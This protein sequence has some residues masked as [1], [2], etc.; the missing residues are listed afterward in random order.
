MIQL[1]VRLLTTVFISA[2]LCQASGQ[3]PT[4]PEDKPTREEAFRAAV[5]ILEQAEQQQLDDGAVQATQTEEINRRLT[6][7]Q[8]VDP[9][10]PWLLYLYGRA[11][12][13]A[14]RT[15]EAI[16]H[17]RKFVETREGRNEWQAHRRLGDLF[18]AEFPRL[19]KAS[20]SKALVL[21][22]GE[23]TALLGLSVCAYKTG[24]LDEAL[25]LAQQAVDADGRQTVRF[26]AQLT[27][28]LIAKQQWADADRTAVLAM[29]LA[30]ADVRKRPGLRGPLKTLEAQFDLLADLS[31]A[32]IDQK[33]AGADD[34]VRL[35]G[36]IRKRSDVSAR[37][38][39]HDA[40]RVLELG[41]N[42]TA[43][44]TPARLQEQYSVT[45]AEVGRTQDAIV[46]FEKLLA[47]D[48]SN[49]TAAEWLERLRSGSNP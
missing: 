38:A 15:G 36:F 4:P 19:A 14:G 3:P 22:A 30:E 10:H 13:L 24:E 47:L 31:Q 17:L 40:L 8:G 39:L 42:S 12:A 44:N 35:A 18:V 6:A 7:L 25:R 43:P 34:F 32:R 2:I 49:A 16:D 46:A 27:R 1:N 33:V 9:S 21:K 29:E 28:M 48:P 41:V 5:E 45:L 26:V 23:A 20:Y 11:H 37:L